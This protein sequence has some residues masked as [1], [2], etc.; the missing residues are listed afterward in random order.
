MGW[1]RSSITTENDWST[2]QSRSAVR[3]ELLFT[4]EYNA[5][6]F[7]LFYTIVYFVCK[8]FFLFLSLLFRAVS[9]VWA[10]TAL[11]PGRQKSPRTKKEDREKR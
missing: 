4:M 1:A 10:I 6:L 5:R 7:V 3:L 9:S 2:C 11:A 8:S